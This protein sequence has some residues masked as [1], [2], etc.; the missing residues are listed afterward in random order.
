VILEHIDLTSCF[1]ELHFAVEDNLSY[2]KL[3]ALVR[4]LRIA[5]ALCCTSHSTI[6]V[7]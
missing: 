5:D 1:E 2:E 7:I 3:I 4:Y 6:T